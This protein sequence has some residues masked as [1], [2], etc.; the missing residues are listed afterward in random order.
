MRRSD[1]MY[2]Q[3]NSIIVYIGISGHLCLSEFHISPTIYEYCYT[4]FYYLYMIYKFFLFFNNKKRPS[5][6]LDFIIGEPFAIYLQKKLHIL[7][8]QAVSYSDT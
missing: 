4:F 3:P 2:K 6:K 7:M 1:C 8:N 5:Y